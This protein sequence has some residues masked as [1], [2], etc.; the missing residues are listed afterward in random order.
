MSGFGTLQNAKANLD[1]FLSNGL[2]V[3]SGTVQTPASYSGNGT[4]NC[5]ATSTRTQ[6][7]VFTSFT[8]GVIILILFIF[9]VMLYSIE[10]SSKSNEIKYGTISK[11]YFFPWKSDGLKPLSSKKLT[12]EQKTIVSRKQYTFLFCITLT[13]ALLLAIFGLSVELTNQDIKE[14]EP[15]NCETKNEK[16]K[17]VM[18]IVAF[19]F[20]INLLALVY[21]AL[22]R[23]QCGSFKGVVPTISGQVVLGIATLL[24]LPTLIFNAMTYK[25]EECL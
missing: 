16:R 5:I 25:S 7:S 14:E 24:L 22:M 20:T 21:F 15:L 18:G 8:A 2:V 4:V 1:N 19:L 11:H 3:P 6:S 9:T 13:F 10:S 12:S 23:Y 17:S